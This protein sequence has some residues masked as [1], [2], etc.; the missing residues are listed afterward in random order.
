MA[1][2]NAILTPAQQVRLREI[3]I[4]LAGNGAA[5]DAEV[6]KEIAVTADQKSKIEELQKKANAARMTLGERMRA[7]A[8]RRREGGHFALGHL[9]PRV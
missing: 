8:F 2:A 1:E 3:A 4:Q 9:C 7:G 6:A 5:Q